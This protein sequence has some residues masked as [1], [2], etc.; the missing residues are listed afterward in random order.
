MYRSHDCRQ[1]A[2]EREAGKGRPGRCSGGVSV[3]SLPGPLDPV[4]SRA[5]RSLAG[6]GR[7]P[8]DRDVNGVGRA[9]TNRDAEFKSLD[10]VLQTSRDFFN[11]DL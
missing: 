9:P 3:E 11:W 1:R 10:V 4:E 5:N 8:C 6:R 2:V 7:L